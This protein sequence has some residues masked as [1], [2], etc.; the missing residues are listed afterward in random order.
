[1]SIKNNAEAVFAHGQATPRSVNF[2]DF[3]V[4]GEMVLYFENTTDRDS[5][6]NQTKQAASLQLTGQG[7]GGGFSEFLKVNFYQLSMATFDLET[8][9]SNFY[10]EKV[11]FTAEYDNVNAKTID[12]V[13]QNTKTLYI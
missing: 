8:G 4:T 13:L 7:I 9:L 3:E 11:Q 12:M 10:A 2:K 1:V 6:Y 5:F